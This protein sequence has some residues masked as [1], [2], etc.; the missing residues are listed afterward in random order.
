MLYLP[1]EIPGAKPV[2]QAELGNRS[3]AAP[4][5]RFLFER[6]TF[7]YNASSTFDFTK[8]PMAFL[9]YLGGQPYTARKSPVMANMASSNYALSNSIDFQFKQTDPDHP[10]RGYYIGNTAQMSPTDQNLFTR[11][12]ELRGYVKGL[13]DK[14]PLDMITVMAN[15]V[16]F[17]KPAVADFA[18]LDSVVLK[19]AASTSSG[20]ENYAVTYVAHVAP[21]WW[22]NAGLEKV[23][24]PTFAPKTPNAFNF[25]TAITMFF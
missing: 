9:G 23:T 21:G 6:A 16:G 10:V 2:Y 1:F 3:E 11:Y 25:T 20:Q 5:S 17:S 18:V 24:H 19:E 22:W 8:G 12:L 4:N 15:Y 13:F 14:R 7:I